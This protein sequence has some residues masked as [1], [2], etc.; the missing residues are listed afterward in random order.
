MAKRAGLRK[1]TKVVRGKKGSVRR[2][3]WVSQGGMSDHDTSEAVVRKAGR[4]GYMKGVMNSELG[5][6][7]RNWRGAPMKDAQ[8]NTHGRVKRI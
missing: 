2:S 3:Y 6:R 5:K 8:G 4:A 7:Y 1:I